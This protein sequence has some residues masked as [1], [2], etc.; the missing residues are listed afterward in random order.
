MGEDSD[1]SIYS[2]SRKYVPKNVLVSTAP[3]LGFVWWNENI[4]FNID[5]QNKISGW[6]LSHE[7]TLLENLTKNV[8]EWRDLDGDGIMFLDQRAGGYSTNEEMVLTPGSNEIRKVPFPH[9]MSTA[10]ANSLL[11]PNSG[12]VTSNS[13]VSS[14]N[15]N[16]NGAFGMPQHHHQSSVAVERPSLSKYATSLSNKL[17]PSLGSS[18]WPN[19]HNT[20]HHNSV[21]SGSESA[22]Q[23]P[24]ESSLQSPYLISLDLPHILSSIRNSRLQELKKQVQTAE[25]LELKSSPTEVFKFLARELK[26][27]YKQ[28]K[29]NQKENDDVI[30][31][32]SKEELDNSKIHLMEK[33]GLAEN[34]TWS[35]LIRYTKSHESEDTTSKATE[36]QT[37][38]TEKAERYEKSVSTNQHELDSTPINDAVNQNKVKSL[39][40]IIT[41]CDKNAETYLMIED[42][43]NYKVWLMMRDALLWDLKELSDNITI[44]DQTISDLNNEPNSNQP[45]TKN[46]SFTSLKE[47]GHDSIASS[48]S[49]FSATDLSSSLNTKPRNSYNEP[50]HLMD[51]IPVSMLKA[52]IEESKA[53]TTIS[54]KD[55]IQNSLQAHLE[56][57]RNMKLDHA[58]EVENA[59][60]EEEGNQKQSIDIPKRDDTGSKDNSNISQSGSLDESPDLSDIHNRRPR[61]SF[62]DTFIS[63]LRSPGSPNGDQDYE[64]IASKRSS[65]PSF[66]SSTATF[67]AMKKNLVQNKTNPSKKNGGDVTSILESDIASQLSFTL[68]PNSKQVSGIT[69][70]LNEKKRDKEEITPPWSSKNVIQQ[71]YEHSVATGNIL[72]TMNIL[73][74]FQDMFHLVDNI[75]IKDSI[76]EFTTLLHRYELFEIA[77]EL[78]KYCPYDDISASNSGQST[79]RTFCDSCG[80][81]LVNEESKEKFTAEFHSGSADAMH[82][83]GYWY[84]DLCSKKN[85]LCCYCNTPMK[86]LA[87]CLLNCGHEAHFHCFKQWFLD[88][89]M[90]VCPLGCSGILL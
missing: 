73:L 8:V 19:M 78:L 75:V 89:R 35:H 64:S 59:I 88:D 84:C 60:E 29:P 71:I 54:R 17:S 34:N 68:N 80:K 2:L 72:L 67:L 63:Q 18:H 76:A 48:Y 36:P 31:L 85:T 50:K 86:S 70:L 46:D 30:S 1:V 20:S 11:L 55:S 5:K 74:L 10:T 45:W 51:N 26:F 69:A 82:K 47:A 15:Y 12:Q 32:H 4:V 38:L 3:S 43:T 79:V 22:L 81:L 77:A 49:S 83:F 24:V 28:E 13:T 16:K 62:I 7:P 52:Q 44:D 42:F 33:L 40:D 90:E 14:V 61:T 65:M 37:P 53:T 39:I 66:S 23:A 58:A 56:E 9:R 87:L 6:N 21:I 25:L 41:A 27:S 57:I